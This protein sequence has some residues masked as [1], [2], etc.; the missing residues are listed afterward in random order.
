M[1]LTRK[2]LKDAI[3]TCA[4]LSVTTAYKDAL[5]D[6]RGAEF[7]TVLYDIM[8]EQPPEAIRAWT[9]F[10]KCTV[11][12]LEDDVR[13]LKQQQQALKNRGTKSGAEVPAL[14]K[15]ATRAE[16][17]EAQHRLNANKGKRK[18]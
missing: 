9:P 8:K 11:P 3:E 14:K 13:E 16:V 2:W 10:V 6:A 17:Q 18:K 1:K 7:M 4:Y 12:L 15:N 5:Y